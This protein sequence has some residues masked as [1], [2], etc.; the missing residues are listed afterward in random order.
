MFISFARENPE[1]GRDVHRAY[2]IT[3]MRTGIRSGSATHL[4]RRR[5]RRDGLFRSTWVAAIF[6]AI[7]FTSVDARAG[8]ETLSFTD[9]EDGQFD[10]SDFLLKHK[11]ALPVPILITEPAVGYGLG[12][13]LLFFSD[14]SS[15]AGAGPPRNGKERV[16]PN[17]TPRTVHG[18][19][20]R[21]TSTPGTMT[22]TDILAQLPK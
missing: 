11:G 20:P 3:T 9:P 16:P 2:G 5:R 4:T 12:L 1:S 6:S 17:V 14:P 22:D 8:D 10:V 19:P 7:V 18:P 13:G 15:D 21:L